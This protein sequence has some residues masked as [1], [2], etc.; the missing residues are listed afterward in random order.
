G[1]R[2]AVDYIARKLQ[3]ST[4]GQRFSAAR[5]VA[6]WRQILRER[7]LEDGRHERRYPFIKSKSRLTRE[8]AREIWDALGETANDC[9]NSRDLLLARVYEI[10]GFTDHID[11]FPYESIETVQTAEDRALREVI[12]PALIA[13]CLDTHHRRLNE[14]AST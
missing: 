11:E 8:L 2:D 12:L 9:G 10:D 5:T 14:G 6:A 1:A 7:R 3:G 4:G 13:A